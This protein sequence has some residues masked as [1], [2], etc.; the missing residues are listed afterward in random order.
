MFGTEA[1]QQ[2]GDDLQADEDDAGEEA[3]DN[4]G[5]GVRTHESRV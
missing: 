5:V 1:I 4:G 2:A 3:V